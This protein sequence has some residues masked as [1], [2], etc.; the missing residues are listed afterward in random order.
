MDKASRGEDDSQEWARLKAARK[1]IDGLA[2]EKLMIVS[3]VFNLT[4]R[5]VQELD[6]SIGETEHLI[7]KQQANTSSRSQEVQACLAAA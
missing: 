3:K 2:E 7:N 1:E 6:E 4:Q 5:F